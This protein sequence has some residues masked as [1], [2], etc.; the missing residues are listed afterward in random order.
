[1][2]MAMPFEI[3]PAIDLRGGRVVRLRRGDFGR[4]TVYAGEPSVVAAGFAEAGARWVHVV[5]L[6]G[7]RSGTPVHGS[8]I[9]T[10]VAS[11]D[12]AAR[13][14]VA[15]GLRDEASVAAVLAWC[16]TGRRRD[17][18]ARRSILRRPADRSSW[19]RQ[20]RG[21]HRYP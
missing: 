6:D 4:E 16:R 2:V 17:G 8:T 14:E 13:V 19:G 10:I 20:D 11:V 1:M 21:R 7:A 5:D 9:A 18:G 15:G 3:I 12:R